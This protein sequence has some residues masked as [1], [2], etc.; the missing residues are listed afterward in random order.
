MFNFFECEQR[1][2]PACAQS[3]ARLI[4]KNKQIK[5]NEPSLLLSSVNLWVTNFSARSLM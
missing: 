3:A 5:L 1:P 2:Q 4:A